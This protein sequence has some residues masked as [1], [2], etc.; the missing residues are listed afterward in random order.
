MFSASQLS[1]KKQRL[2]AQSLADFDARWDEGA[3]LLLSAEEPPHH[4]TRE[5]VFYALALLIRQGPG[6]ADRADRILRAVLALQRL[7]AGQIWHGTFASLL[8]QPAP[9]RAPFDVSELTP[10]ARWQGDVLGERL[11]AA[12]T[13]R[14]RA[15]P[16]LAGR[17]GEISGLLA[18][19]LR[20]VF[21]VVWETYD[22]NWREFILATMALILEEFASLL[23]AE[24]VS[25]M[26]QAARE[27]L[28]GARFRAERGL[29]PLNTNVEVMH[30][31]IFDAFAR[32]FGDGELSAYAAAFARRFLA[33]Y[34]EHHAVAEFNSPTY[35]GVVLSY[36][37]LLRTRGG[38]P[39]VREMG[40]EL[41]EGL[42]E[43]LAEFYNPVM[44]T[45]SGP[46][47]RAYG[48]TIDGTAIPMLMYLGL[49]EIPETRLPSFGGETES[50]CVLCC[51]DPAI[52]ERVRP[53]LLYS[54]GE[55]QVEHCFR[56][57]AER[58][59][60]GENRSLCTAT[61]WITDDLML[62]AMR[63]STNTSHQLHAAVAH[64]RNS[65]GGV[66][67][68]R[69]RRRTAD[70][71]LVHLRTAFF[72]FTARPGEISGEVRNESAG[73]IVCDFEVE[74]P[75]AASGSYAGGL[76]RVDGLRCE[77]RLVRVAPDGTEASAEAVPETRPDGSVW[78]A[79]PLARDASLRVRLSFSLE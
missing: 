25:A 67:S 27:G 55:R 75:G 11:G 62:G 66:S 69:L 50:A 13:A 79:V 40:A 57:L 5:S 45:L 31:F 42:W 7:D 56:E 78:L 70:G 77:A 32:R 17:A 6:D 28:K 64:W 74:S 52:P 18:A 34:R 29:T 59:K 19:S 4:G 48:T 60:P 33:D 26:E 43:D 12:F 21:P 68:L 16:S 41:E 30:V 47:T 65:A 61:S 76:W 23:P 2:L 53:A 54:R 24:T 44:K 49:D 15:D 22:P 71:R 37:G 9:V 73:D 20:D 38:S 58:G 3:S 35:N 63:G 14:L 72:D 51:A 36:T 1:L 39:E 10:V 8:E 46:F